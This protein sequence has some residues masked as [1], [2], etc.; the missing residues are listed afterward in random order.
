ML[1]LNSGMN[2]S[3]SIMSFQNI[4]LKILI[5]LILLQIIFGAFV[6]GL[7]AGKIYQTWPLMNSSYIPDDTQ[8]NSLISVLDFNNKSLVQFIHRNLA[9]FIFFYILIISSVIFKDKNQKIKKTYLYVTF[10]LFLQIVLGIYTLL[11]GLNTLVALLHQITSVLLFLSIVRL[12][13]VNLK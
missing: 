4:K 9:Y 5:P 3:F 8:F 1:N 6:S 13:Y 11:S 2:N 12:N 10:F 7:D